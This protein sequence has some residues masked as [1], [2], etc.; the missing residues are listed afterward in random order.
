MLK[1]RRRAKRTRHSAFYK[2]GVYVWIKVAH[3]DDGAQVRSQMLVRAAPHW[4][5]LSSARSRR[6]GCRSKQRSFSVGR[7]TR[8]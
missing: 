2:P 8:P 7:S 6:S 4:K 5:E 3:D 1:A